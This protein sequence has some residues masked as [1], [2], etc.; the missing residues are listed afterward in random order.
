[1][2]DTLHHAWAVFYGG[3]E[4]VITHNT[5]MHTYA[6]LGLAPREASQETGFP[7]QVYLEGKGNQ[8]DSRK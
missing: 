2:Y 3:N 6:H 1:M 5:A 8:Q 4:G 7:V